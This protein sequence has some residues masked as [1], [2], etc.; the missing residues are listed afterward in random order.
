MKATF[1][2]REKNDVKFTMEFTAE[3]FESAQIKVYQQAKGQFAIDGFR[4]GKAPRSIIEKHY[5]EGVFFEDAINDLISENYGKTL[6]ELGLEVVGAPSADFSE[7]AKGQGFTVTITVP[8]FPIVEV[9]DYKGVE[10][11]KIEQEVKDEDVEREIENLQKR[12]ARIA[13]V[14]RAAQ[15]GDTVLFDYA[16]FVG[17]EQFEGGTA[18]RQELKLGSGMFIPGFEEQLVGVAA[19]EDKDVEVTFPEEYH[20]PDLAGKAA[21]F[22]CHVHEVKE[23]QLPELDDEFAKDVSEFDTLEELK[24]SHR[25]R[26]E[27]YAKAGSESA[28]KDAALAKVVEANEVEVP[29]SMI[30]DEMDRMSQELDQQLRYQGLS[31]AQYLEFTGKTQEDFRGELRPDAERQVKTRII[32]TGIVEAEKIEVAD[33]ELEEELKMMGI[34]YQMP[35]DKVKEAIGEEGLV[36]F[37]KDLQVKKAIDFI[38]DNAIVK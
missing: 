33:E 1:I 5:G 10:I 3:E 29:A 36:Y 11:E 20:A 26:L 22:H 28:M 27:S 12:N 16:G 32:L 19:G 37:K 14:E 18:E 23:E 17:E 7:V 2:S 15:E 31:I 8:C 30:E 34:Q 6:T 21:V 25:E 4:K 13:I 35:V 38:F 24:Q 9:K